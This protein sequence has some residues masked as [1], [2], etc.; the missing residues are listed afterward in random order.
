MKCSSVKWGSA[1][2]DTLCLYLQNSTES[3]FVKQGIWSNG[4]RTTVLSTQLR[5][6]TVYIFTLTVQKTDRGAASVNQTVSIYLTL[7]VCA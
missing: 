6:G 7:T 2:A 4:S 3:H 1:T 5:A